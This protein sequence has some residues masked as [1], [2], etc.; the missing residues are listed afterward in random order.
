MAPSNP[1]G[2]NERLRSYDFLRG[3]AIAGI[4]AVHTFI[5]FRTNVTL[6]DSAFSFGRYGVQLFFLVSAMTM[7]HMWE[8]RLGEPNRAAGFYIR[9]F[10]RIAPLF[11]LAIIIYTLTKGFT[12]GPWL[13]P[14]TGVKEIA[15]T[16]LFLHGFLPDCISS[17]VPG[18]WSI[19]VE[20][21]FYAI[22]PLI[23]IKL[24]DKPARYLLAAILVYFAYAISI[25]TPLTDYILSSYG[26]IGPFIADGFIQSNFLSQLPVFLLGCY[27][28]FTIKAKKRTGFMPY[29]IFTSWIVLAFVCEFSISDPPSLQGAF[30]LITYLALTAVAALSVAK[31]F[32]FRPLEYLGKKSYEIYLSHFLILDGVHMLFVHYGLAT[33]GMLSFII[34]YA[35]TI[36]A[37]C[38]IAIVAERTIERN[39]G[40]LRR[41]L[42]DR[43]CTAKNAAP[44][45]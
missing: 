10:L 42:L 25:K 41:R 45:A 12:H 21:T 9:R 34:V 32:H 24:G 22:F 20:M 43:F 23:I 7:C 28:F 1:P 18:G 6:L 15:S 31:N 13:T 33:Q 26:A 29:A 35:V 5:Y 30:F 3:L 44:T 38:F 40:K 17:I 8:T 16:A 36:A 37:T 27:I 4:V 11:W 39:V 14:V 19:A 2:G